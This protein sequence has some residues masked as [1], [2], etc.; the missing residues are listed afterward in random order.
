MTIDWTITYLLSC[1]L[2]FREGEMPLLEVSVAVILARPVSREI[3][4]RLTF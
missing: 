2:A 3:V 1:N 4:L